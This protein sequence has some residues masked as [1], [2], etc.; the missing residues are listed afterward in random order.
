MFVKGGTLGIVKINTRTCK[1]RSANKQIKKHR[2]GKNKKASLGCRCF[3][4]GGKGIR[5]KNVQQKNK[6]KNI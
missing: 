4:K 6:H 2:G 3:T 1:Q 5:K